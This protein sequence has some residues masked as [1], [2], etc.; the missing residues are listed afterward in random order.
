MHI[1]L[2]RHGVAADAGPG[3][4]DSDRALTDEGWRRLRHAA[5]AWRRVME[6]PD[7]IFVSPLRRARE[8]SS[9]LLEALRCGTE[10]RVEPALQPEAPPRLA[11][12]LLEAESA[13]GTRAVALVGHE[14]HLGYLLGLLLTGNPRQ[15]VPLKKG[16][17]V[18][19]ETRSI[20]SL[21]AD[22]RFALTQRA[23]GDLG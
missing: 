14:P 23:A 10:P 20:A 8:T 17:L 11:E 16:M 1:Y 9:V 19:V 13:S 15:P 2:L 18:G 6:V 7:V 21:S 5:P 12:A 4:P 3:T 22:L